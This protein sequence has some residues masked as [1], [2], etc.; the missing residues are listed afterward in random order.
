MNNIVTIAWM[1][2]LTK[3]IICVFL[4][5]SVGGCIFGPSSSRGVMS[6]RNSRVYL[7]GGGFYKVGELPSGWKKFRTSSKAI[8]FYNKEF[9]SSITTDAFCGRSF[10]DNPLEV[11]AGELISTLANHGAV[12]TKELMLGGRKAL[13]MSAEGDMDGADVKMDAVV[14][15]KGHC[16]FDFILVSPSGADEKVRSEFEDFFKPF[17]Y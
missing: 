1:N 7:Q 10:N 5:S 8:S 4:L 17:E 9:S 16:N 6:Y 13:R 15:K 12:S 3:I 14:L 2:R 11:L